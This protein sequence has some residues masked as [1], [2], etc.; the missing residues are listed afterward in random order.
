MPGIVR[1]RSG[2]LNLRALP[3]TQAEVIASIP[4]GADVTVLGQWGNWYVVRYGDN[5]GYAHS[6]YIA[7]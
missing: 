4:N 7:I 3:N 2:T 1:L 6:A 5:V